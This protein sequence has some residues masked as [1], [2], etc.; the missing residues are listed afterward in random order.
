[1]TT[2]REKMKQEM[3]LRGLAAGTQKNYLRAIVALHD[4]Y[5]RSPARLTEE[6]IKTYL[7]TIISDRK[8]APSTYNVIIHGLK[9]FYEIVLRRKMNDIELPRM[10]EPQKLPDILSQTEVADIIKV[11]TNLQYKTIFILMYGAGFRAAEVAALSINDIDN[12]RSI[13]H[14]RQGKGNKDR[15]VLLSPV[16]YTHLR[17]YWQKCR[18][19]SYKVLAN[20]HLFTNT[21]GRPL[22]PSSIGAA[23][24]HSKQKANIKKLGGVHSLRHA[25]ATHALESGADLFAIKQ[26]LGHASITSTVRYLRMTTSTLQAITSPVDALSL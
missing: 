9:F 15:Y 1:M 4:H 11:T 17:S 22:S 24:R 19:A 18:A 16:M 6:E 7:L 2:L 12:K 3:T 25:F 21:L 14:I 8:L 20:D 10:K 26:L 5:R 13:I 23:Y